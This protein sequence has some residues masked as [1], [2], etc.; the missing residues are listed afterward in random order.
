MIM[1]APQ[2]E[3]CLVEDASNATTGLGPI[4]DHVPQTNQEVVGIG[5]DRFQGRVVAVNISYD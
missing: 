3:I 5:Q 1:V 4:P 2:D